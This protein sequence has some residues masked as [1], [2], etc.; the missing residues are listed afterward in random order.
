MK[1]WNDENRYH[2]WQ[3]KRNYWKETL[4]LKATVPWLITERLLS[5]EILQ[6]YRDSHVPLI[7]RCTL[8]ILSHYL[9]PTPIRVIRVKSA[10]WR[11][12]V[13]K[14]AHHDNVH[15]FQSL[16]LSSKMHGQ[17]L[18]KYI[19]DQQ[20]KITIMKAQSLPVFSSDCKQL[21]EAF[22]TIF[23]FKSSLGVT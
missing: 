6:R 12:P 3:Y 9:G 23:K 21:W 20:V 13:C 1:R 14:R 19:H 17:V 22:K 11:F 18:P 5:L 4:L 7:F 15:W 2:D 10:L 8:T 16:Q